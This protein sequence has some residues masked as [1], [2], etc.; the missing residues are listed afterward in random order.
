MRWPIWRG[1][2]DWRLQDLLTYSPPV[3]KR[4][5]T[6]LR[7]IER[8]LS[9][10]QHERYRSLA[11]IYDITPWTQVCNREEFIMNLYMCSTSVIASCRP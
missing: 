10:S 9:P 6:D 1:E 8:G 2:L 11:N 7:Q 4:T 3:L 5:V